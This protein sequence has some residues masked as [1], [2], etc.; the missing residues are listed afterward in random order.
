[1]A[2]GN[3]M[4]ICRKCN[5]RVESAGKI[6]RAC[7]S[8]LEEV[9]DGQSL[10]GAGQV[11]IA[12]VPAPSGTG[13]T[14][15]V[16]LLEDE[17]ESS[18]QEL[19]RPDWKCPKCGETVP[20]NFDLCWKCL[21]TETGE[22]APTYSM[23][24][25]RI[26]LACCFPGHILHI[27][28]FMFSIFLLLATLYHGGDLGGLWSGGTLTTTPGMIGVL[29]FLSFGFLIKRRLFRSA[30]GTRSDRLNAWTLNLIYLAGWALFWVSI[31]RTGDGTYV[32]ASALGLLALLAGVSIARILHERRAA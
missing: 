18:E 8:I 16:E 19:S 26:Y 9:S 3:A 17:G 25:E 22:P 15:P 1:M 7:G 24:F 11:G 21:P 23:K 31:A 30:V 10:D 13:S 14:T 29:T 12:S 20:G 32:V 27:L 28:G 4:L 6:C 2:R 5:K